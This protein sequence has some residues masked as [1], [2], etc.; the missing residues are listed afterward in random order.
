VNKDSKVC[1]YLNY[2]A[3]N[4]C[5]FIGSFNDV[6]LRMCFINMILGSDQENAGELERKRLTVL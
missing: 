4:K 3:P 6:F 5:L 1:G 2:T